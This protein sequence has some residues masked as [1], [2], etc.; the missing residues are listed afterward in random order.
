MLFV[1]DGPKG[2]SWLLTHCGTLITA[3]YKR[4]TSSVSDLLKLK[5]DTVA[6]FAVIP[7]YPRYYRG[8]GIE[9]IIIIIIQYLYSAIMSYA[10][11]EAYYRK[12]EKTSF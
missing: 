12:V 10:D 6:V 7:R 8:N 4:A 1:Y 5:S 3:P 2:W 9:I 11:T